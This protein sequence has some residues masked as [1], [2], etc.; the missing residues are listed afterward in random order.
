MKLTVLRNQI[1]ETSDQ[2]LQ[3]A[4]FARIYDN[5][6]SQE[7][8]VRRLGN[9]HYPRLH[10]YIKEEGERII[11]EMHLDQKQASYAGSHMHN[12]DYDGPVVEAEINRLR[13]LIAAAAMPLAAMQPDKVL[14]KINNRDQQWNQVYDDDGSQSFVNEN[15]HRPWW[16]KL[17]GI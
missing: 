3:R 14:K 10:M 17:L 12:A 1:S 11:F 8:F 2:F 6:R 4:G 13:E 7:S 9:Y 16:K 5:R 15:D